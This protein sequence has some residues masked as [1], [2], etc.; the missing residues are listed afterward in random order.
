MFLHWNSA[1]PVISCFIYDND[2]VAMLAGVTWTLLVQYCFSQTDWWPLIC[3]TDLEV[4]GNWSDSK[5]WYAGRIII[6]GRVN[7]LHCPLPGW[8]SFSVGKYSQFDRL[9]V[10]SFTFLVTS[11]QP[12][13]ATRVW[14]N[15][16]NGFE[17]NSS[18]THTLLDI[19]IWLYKLYIFSETLQGLIMNVIT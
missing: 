9:V 8:S 19:S 16:L 5:H 13:L 7:M 14:I 10:F 2:N 17:L 18:D 12:F 4:A 3:L 6:N 1:W 11:S 15:S